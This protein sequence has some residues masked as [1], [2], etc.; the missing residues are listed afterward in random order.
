VELCAVW[1]A[2]GGGDLGEGSVERDRGLFEREPLRTLTA[3]CITPPSLPAPTMLAHAHGVGQPAHLYPQNVAAMWARL[4]IVATWQQY[5]PSRTVAESEAWDEKAPPERGFHQCAREDSNLH[6][7][8]GPQGPQ[9]CAS[10][11]SA[12]GAWRASIA[13]ATG[14]SDSV[15]PRWTPPRLVSVRQ[16]RYV[17]EHMFDRGRVAGS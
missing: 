15:G 11:N 17:H 7:P 6:G 1:A 5:P 16:P 4:L 2:G 14:P 12:T 13:L 9:P 8:I 3:R 10:T